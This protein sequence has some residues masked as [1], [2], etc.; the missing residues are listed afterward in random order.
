[1]EDIASKLNQLQD[2]LNKDLITQEDFDIK[3]SSL[4]DRFMTETA[5]ET[6]PSTIDPSQEQQMRDELINNI[7]P[8]FNESAGNVGNID[9]IGTGTLVEMEKYVNSITGSELE[10]VY[11]KMIKNLNMQMNESTRPW[12]NP[13]GIEHFI[14]EDKGFTEAELLPDLWK[15]LKKEKGSLIKPPIYKKDPKN[16]NQPWKPHL[17]LNPRYLTELTGNSDIWSSNPYSS[18]IGYSNTN[19]NI[20]N[21]DFTTGPPNPHQDFTTSYPMPP[22]GAAG[23]NT[24]GTIPGYAKGGKWLEG[25]LSLFSGHTPKWLINLIEKTKGGKEYVEDLINPQ[26]KARSDLNFGFMKLMDDLHNKFDDQITK[27]ETTLEEANK[28][29]SETMDLFDKFET[30]E[31]NITKKRTVFPD[32]TVEHGTEV[33]D[34]ITLDDL[35]EMSWDEAKKW[36]YKKKDWEY[37]QKYKGKD[38]KA[39]FEKEGFKWNEKEQKWIKEEVTEDWSLVPDEYRP[40]EFQENPQGYDKAV[41]EQIEK[42]KKKGIF[43]VLQGG[44]DDDRS[45]PGLAKGSWFKGSGVGG[46]EPPTHDRG[47]MKS[48]LKLGTT[49]GMSEKELLMMAIKFNWDVSDDL[50]MKYD[51]T[52]KDLQSESGEGLEWLLLKA[53][54]KLAKQPYSESK[55]NK[56]LSEELEDKGKI[57]TPTQGDLFKKKSGGLI[58]LVS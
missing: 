4:S 1:M 5:P 45:P 15:S 54:P 20:G 19:T 43:E 22:K 48:L 31:P 11:N 53:N 12:V 3:Y 55:I 7:I 2:L 25:I 14:G 13:K 40:I 24:G 30:T 52:D 37:M 10:Q 35:K 51:I 56:M 18:N 29:L 34:K 41:K 58:S 33:R 36:G 50:R 28:K 9:Q 6:A 42:E 57:I 49:M 46:W 47:L 32:G 38:Y 39:E 21:Q 26:D 27:S 23:F 17:N 44:K 16:I 8:M